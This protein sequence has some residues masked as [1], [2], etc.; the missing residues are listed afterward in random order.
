MNTPKV[1]YKQLLRVIP[2]LHATKESSRSQLQGF[3]DFS[4]EILERTGDLLR[5]D[6]SH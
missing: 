2:K 5:I 1:I 6:I 4:L 3:M